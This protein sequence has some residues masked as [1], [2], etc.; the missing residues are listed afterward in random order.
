MLYFFENF[1][2]DPARREL[3]RDNALIAVQ[4]QVFDLL[5]YL[6]TN[7]DRVVSKDDILGAVW[8]GRIVSESALTTRINAT[9]TAV[10]DD[11]DQQ[12]LIRTIPRK[13]IR[14]VGVVQ[15]R[16]QPVEEPPAAPA[17]LDATGHDKAASAERRQLTIASCEL[18][19]GA[20][21]MDPED[22]TEIIQ[23]YHSCVAETIGR[24][25]GLVAHTY[26]NADL[27]CFGYPEA[28]EDD[29]ERAVRAALELVSAVAALKT[30][31]PLQTRIGIATG[32]V[33]VSDIAQEGAHECGIIGDAPN[34]AT[35][36]QA[37]AKP[38]TVIIAENTR[39][40]LGNLFELEDLGTKDFPGVADP[41]H[42]WTV[43]RA[44]P[45]VGR[46]EAFHAT[47][48]TALVGREEELELLLRRWSKAKAG[49]GQ[50]VLLC[51]EAGIGKSRLTAALLE[52]IATEP[53]TRLRN[54]CSPQYTDSALYPTIGQIERA[55]GFTRDDTLRAKLDKLDAV[56]AQSSTSAQDAALFAEMLSLPNDGRYSVLELTP[57]QR[58][59]RTL[60]AL[61]L[62]V[63]ILSRQNP[64]LM[65]F[66]DAQWIDPTSLELF[67]RIV[68]RIRTLRVLLIM[69]Y[70]PEFQ[71]PWLGRPYVTALTINRLTEREAG[72]MI[73]RIVGAKPLPASFRNSII[74]RSDGIPL[75]VEEITKAVLEAES[76]SAA[77][78][79]IAAVP[80]AAVAVPATLHASLMA[81]LD[82]LGA[83]AKEL[84][85]IGAAIGREFSH[86][87]LAAVVDKPE[88]ELHAALD[89]IVAAGLLFGQGVAPRATYLFK[90]ALIQDAAYDTLL[91]EPRRAL[92]AHIADTLERQFAD[93]TETR[94][95]ILARHCAEAGLA[96]KAATLWGRAGQRSLEQSALVEAVEQFTRGLDQ[97]ATLSSTPALRSQQ[98]KLQVGLANALYHT[99]G[100]SAVETKAAFDHARA[101][102]DRSEALGE[103]VEEPLVL[104][105]ILYGFFIAKFIPFE[106]EAARA[107]ASQFLE[108]AE[109]QKATALIMI[110]HRLLGTTLL[111]L[112]EPAEGLK[113][114]DQAAALYEPAAHRSLTTHFGHD[115]GA[116]TL[117]LRSLALWLLGY[118]ETAL[119]EIEHALKAARETVHAPTLMFALGMTTFTQICCR[120]YARASAQIDECATLASEK[121]A[122]YWKAQAVAHRG[123]VTALIGNFA[124]AIQMID[125]GIMETRSIGATIWTPWWLSHL[126]LSHANLRKFD[127]A[128]RCIDEA[129]SAVEKT[130][131][132]WWEPE[133]RRTAG[134]IALMSPQQDA[135]KAQEC[136]D[137][138]LRIAHKQQAKSLELRAAMSLARLWRDQGKPQQARDLLAPVYGWFTEGF[139]TRD[140]KEAKAL[141]DA[142]AA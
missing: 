38:G 126:A 28:H 86:A 111:C 39:K 110:G 102:I 108:L 132:S 116:A 121:S 89:R 140:L 122:S 35:R 109:Q 23:S 82:R 125:A 36:L 87:L 32:L 134:E 58:R 137:R 115:V 7:R 63:A 72:A 60:E 43:L 96:E 52:A 69:T 65:I 80:P 21:A 74:E 51:G 18:L 104:Y 49:E 17:V 76:Q 2:L 41:V 56:L 99:K 105:S 57:Q 46:F 79:G 47:G 62:Q 85:Q 64:V 136:Y 90:H 6:I 54:F 55:S 84:T 66:E 93:I 68:N 81:R 113:H 42:A 117:S 71:P 95:E 1:V 98:I 123:S 12:R 37:I 26:G 50:V 77:E 15:E 135:A 141:L 106:G 103:H 91:R 73:D 11:G 25:N 45:A 88:A 10:D 107:L 27:V 118:P 16:A 78:L 131:E 75:F 19:R 142:L 29:P 59:Q 44:S 127:D 128:W 120:N 130:K 124:E 138:A 53:H 33:V 5:E 24:H 9:R 48:L 133:V 8:A 70:R 92:H 83:P 31:T 13:G 67:S 97:I 94:P 114:L 22:L 112:G 61:I 30:L 119:A 34:L 20:A 139:D 101:M 129:I 3:R 14:F 40:L 100:F 4:P